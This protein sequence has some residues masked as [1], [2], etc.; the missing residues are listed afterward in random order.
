[1]KPSLLLV[2]ERSRSAGTV[3][4][5]CTRKIEVFSPHGATLPGSDSDSSPA[6]V[7]PVSTFDDCTELIEHAYD[8][9]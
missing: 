3:C 2:C 8:D 9:Q 6:Q 5:V 7:L 4:G 1:M